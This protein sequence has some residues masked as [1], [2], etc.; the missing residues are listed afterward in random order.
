[1]FLLLVVMVSPSRR[2]SIQRRGCQGNYCLGSVSFF[3]FHVIGGG[4]CQLMNEI[5][6]FIVSM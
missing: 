6:L 4:G 3:L 5:N 2:K 1:M